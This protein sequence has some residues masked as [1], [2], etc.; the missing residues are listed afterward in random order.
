MTFYSGVNYS[1]VL[2]SNSSLFLVT[3][4]GR[5]NTDQRMSH[6]LLEPGISWFKFHQTPLSSALPSDWAYHELYS[7]VVSTSSIGSAPQ[8]RMS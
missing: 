8:P 2:V 7:S 6:N 4:P 1:M 3:S 5:S